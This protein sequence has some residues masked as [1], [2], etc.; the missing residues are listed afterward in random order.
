MLSRDWRLIQLT[1]SWLQALVIVVILG[2]LFVPIYIKAGVSQNTRLC[3]SLLL[4]FADHVLNTAKPLRM[5][6]DLSTLELYYIMSVYIWKVRILCSE[7]WAEKYLVLSCSLSPGAAFPCNCICS[8]HPFAL[9]SCSI[10]VAINFLWFFLYLFPITWSL[11]YSRCR[12]WQCQS[13]W[14][15]VLVGNGFRSTCPS[16]LWSCI[17]SRRSQ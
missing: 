12:W 4:M 7:I 1:L 16:F 17:F 13:I 11:I 5:A 6:W 15:S 3:F 2:W 10:W 8:S 9:H 14:R